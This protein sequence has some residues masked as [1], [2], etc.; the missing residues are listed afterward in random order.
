[1]T[2]NL[3]KHELLNQCA[4]LMQIPQDMK[5]SSDHCMIIGYRN[6]LEAEAR[7]CVMF[8]V[9]K[10]RSADHQSA[11]VAQDGRPVH[12]DPCNW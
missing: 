11:V 1:M 2:K 7:R 8:L 6:M 12:Q 3:F 4:Y 5:V 10:Q 9:R